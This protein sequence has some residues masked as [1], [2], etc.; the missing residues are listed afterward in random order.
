M[1]GAGI[2][3]T[4]WMPSKLDALTEEARTKLGMSRSHFYRYAV[5]RLL[6]EIS[7]LS[8]KIH[9][10]IDGSRAQLKLRSKAEESL[11]N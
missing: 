5:L 3:R 11:E 2:R 10:N 4:F 6:E 8:T 7:V 9:Q 1:K